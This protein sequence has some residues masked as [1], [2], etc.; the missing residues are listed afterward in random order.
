VYAATR[1]PFAH[2]DKRVNP[3][4]LDLTNAAQIR[5]SANKVDSLDVLVNDA[6][7]DLHDDLSDRAGIER[8]LE[9]NLFGTWGVTQAFLPLLAQSHGAIVN[10]PSL[11]YNSAANRNTLRTQ[12]HDPAPYSGVK[13]R[14]PAK[15]QKISLQPCAASLCRHTIAKGRV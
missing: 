7:I 3:L 8:H 10:V 1:R 12:R 13:G 2:S 11:E 9:V 5:E 6:G 4:S 15:E 14:R